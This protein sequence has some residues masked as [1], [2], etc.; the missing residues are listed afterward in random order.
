MESEPL[1]M[2]MSLTVASLIKTLAPAMGGSLRGLC[3]DDVIFEDEDVAA[4]VAAF[5]AL[6]ELKLAR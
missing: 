3:L 6:E 5:P 4:L 1:T 2:F